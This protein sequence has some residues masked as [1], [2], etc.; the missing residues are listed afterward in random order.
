LHG[1][2]NIPALEINFSL[3]GTDQDGCRTP[4]PSSP[5]METH[6]LAKDFSGRASNQL[7][8]IDN[9]EPGDSGDEELRHP[10]LFHGGADM[11]REP[12]EERELTRR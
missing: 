1:S 10:R 7:W 6:N 9:C 4:M 5:K 12:S 8:D 11:N 2:Y 3:A